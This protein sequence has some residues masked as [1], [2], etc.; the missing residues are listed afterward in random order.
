MLFLSFPLQTPQGDG[1]FYSCPLL[2][3]PLLLIPPT[4]EPLYSCIFP[5]PHHYHLSYLTFNV[6]LIIEYLYL[7]AVKT[8][9]ASEFGHLIRI[10]SIYARV[11]H[12]LDEM[13]GSCSTF[14]SHFLGSRM[15]LI[16]PEILGNSA[17]TLV[18]SEQKMEACPSLFSCLF[19]VSPSSLL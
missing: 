9:Y 8:Q 13:N 3:P 5:I 17:A 10:L 4:S 7:P 6:D 12:A 16:A 18:E 14:L 19:L 1:I 11:E 15:L 2:S